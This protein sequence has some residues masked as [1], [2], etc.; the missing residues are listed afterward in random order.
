[1]KKRNKRVSALLLI[2][3]ILAWW[4][5]SAQHNT[6]SNTET[7]ITSNPSPKPDI[8]TT[9]TPELDIPVDAIG[10]RLVGP[11][12]PEAQEMAKYSLV[13]K[14]LVQSHPMPEIHRDF[15]R[16]VE[17]GEI[18][19]NF[20][21]NVAGE[22]ALATVIYVNTPSHGEVLVFSIDPAELNSPEL[23]RAFKQLVIFHEYIH[24]LQQKSGRWPK[25]LAI[26][27]RARPDKPMNPKALRVF[28]EA[29]SQ[30]YEQ[31]CLLAIQEGW[32]NKLN[33]AVAYARG[34]RSAMRLKLAEIYAELPQYAS[35]R[36]MLF[37]IARMK[38]GER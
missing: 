36:D 2:A 27:L 1:M 16:M 21:P 6:P 13:L 11:P 15:N 25:W 33:L 34:G 24:I 31:E 10:P 18:I 35:N 19:L 9:P 20:Q 14:E 8:K 29:E 23:S 38:P 22:H 4:G 32:V 17:N 26:G 30:A 37:R 7:V 5:Y 12:S 28:F 3:G